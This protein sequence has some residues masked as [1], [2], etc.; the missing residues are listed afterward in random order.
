MATHKNNL[1]SFNKTDIPS[2]KGFSFGIIVSEWNNEITSSLLDGAKNTLI[3]CG[4][5]EKNISVLTVPGSFELIYG[6]KLMSKYG[7]D[8]LICL[9]SI[10]KGETKHFDFICNAV[11]N[12]IME[13]NLILDIPVIF[14]V[15]T[16]NTLKQAK[17]RS[18]GKHGNKGIESAITAIKMVNLD[19]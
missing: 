12:G 7:F 2:A 19:V 15:L 13:L 9:G 16:D 1:S 11:T 8:G 14:G 5:L 17:D 10:I 18:G 6:A 4:V 3:E